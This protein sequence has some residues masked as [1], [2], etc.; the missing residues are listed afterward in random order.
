MTL[1]SRMIG[2]TLLVAALLS[3]GEQLW[4]TTCAPGMPMSGSDQ[5]AMPGMPDMSG[6]M[7]G[8]HQA[9]QTQLPDNRER[10]CPLDNALIQ[11]A[12][13]MLLPAATVM[14]SALADHVVRSVS[15][16]SRAPHTV[17]LSSVF[18]PPKL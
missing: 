14:P 11:C 6:P 15:Q 4:A 1:R 7:S 12:L 8:T 5:A 3:I 18:H 13:S 2:I 9:A 16:T 17:Q 10:E